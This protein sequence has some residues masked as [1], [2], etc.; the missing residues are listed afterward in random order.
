[1]GFLRVGLREGGLFG[2]AVPQC[3]TGPHAK[4]QPEKTFQVYFS[5]L[6]GCFRGGSTTLGGAFWPA[7]LVVSG[8][9][10]LV[11][12]SSSQPVGDQQVPCP[13]C[14]VL[15]V[16]YLCLKCKCLA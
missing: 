11:L 2:V 5:R 1:M 6:G 7:H 3:A 16:L 9:G 4:D 13:V 10:G 12:K 15:S 14:A 8:L